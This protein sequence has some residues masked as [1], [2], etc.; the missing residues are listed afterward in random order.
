MENVAPFCI[1]APLNWQNFL[2][3]EGYNPL[4]RPLP[5][6]DKLTCWGRGVDI[7]ISSP[8]EP[9]YGVMYSHNPL[10]L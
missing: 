4:L 2:I 7:I 1:K 9:V 8:E 5:Q 10:L 3:G 6:V